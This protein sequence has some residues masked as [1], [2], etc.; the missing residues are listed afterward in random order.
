MANGDYEVTHNRILNSGKKIFKDQ[1]FEKAN[2]RAICK[3][4]GV[5]TGA[6]YGHFDDKEALFSELVEPIV[7]QIKK[8]YKMYEDKSFD[9]YIRETPITKD[10]INKI[11]ESKS[12]GAIEMVLYFFENKEIFELLIFGSYGTKYSNF[13]DE[14]VEIEDKNHLKILSLIYGENQVKNIITDMGI[15]LINHAY[16]YALSEV[17]VHSESRE[18]ARLNAEL[19]TKFFNEGWGKIRGL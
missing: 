12:K 7:S 18:E 1:G 10:T 8:Y 17:A 6:F 11:L 5:T 15:H 13:L 19:I 2:L 14:I 16:Y 4:S 3:E 9:I